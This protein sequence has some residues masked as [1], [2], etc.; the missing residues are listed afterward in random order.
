LREAGEAEG[1]L[2]ATSSKNSVIVAEPEQMNVDVV[3]KVSSE[4]LLTDIIDKRTGDPS[5][6]T[7]QADA[8]EVPQRFSEKKR[9]H[10]S[11]K[12]CT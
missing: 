5:P 10:W 12:T 9:L 11:G 4:T 8:P 7:S 2:D 6:I 3:P 1:K